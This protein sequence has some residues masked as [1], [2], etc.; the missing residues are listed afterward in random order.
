MSGAFGG[1]A[2]T[3]SAVI[4]TVDAAIADGRFL[5]DDPT[6]TAAAQMAS[7]V[8]LL[9]GG[10]PIRFEA[11]TGIP[12]SLG[13]MFDTALLVLISDPIEARRVARAWIAGTASGADLSPVAARAAL[14][15]IDA[16][17][18]GMPE[19]PVVWGTRALH[20][21][22]AG[23]EASAR[24]EWSAARRAALDQAEAATSVQDGELAAL[25]ATLAWPAERSRTVLAE[26]LRE[27]GTIRVRRASEAVGWTG[28][29][30]EAA[31][32]RMQEVWDKT[33]DLREANPSGYHFHDH[34]HAA[35]PD[36]AR[37]K[38]ASVMAEQ[39]AWCETMATAALA[40][41]TTMQEASETLPTT[42]A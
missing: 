31:L 6:A 39:A 35:H 5:P 29:D 14:W 40:L 24:T 18:D 10:D 33:A 32:P 25:A 13:L 41:V 20:R 34:F 11:T 27:L 12:A 9:G 26:G 4:A 23:G 16:A 15:I 30:E 19:L 37:R 3:R 2:A 42:A 36:E 17:V 1:D 21:R 28:A 7:L 38:L 22:A 8:G